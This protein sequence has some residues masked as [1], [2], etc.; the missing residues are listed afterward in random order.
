VH[1]HNCKKYDTKND[2]KDRTANYH[3]A[4]SS[5]DLAKVKYNK[6]RLSIVEKEYVNICMIPNIL[7]D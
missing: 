3:F 7:S 5:L 6:N 1:K 4:H 2:T